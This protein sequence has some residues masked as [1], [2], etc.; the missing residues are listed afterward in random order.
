MN[1]AITLDDTI[2]KTSEMIEKYKKEYIK[3]NNISVDIFINNRIYQEYFYKEYIELIYNSVLLKSY[4]KKALRYLNENNNIYIITNRN[5]LYS[6]KVKS[7]TLNYLLRNGIDV[8]GI[9]FDCKDKFKFCKKNKIDIIIDNNIDNYKKFK[10]AKIKYI[11]YDDKEKYKN[12]DSIICSWKYDL[13][14]ETLHFIM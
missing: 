11:L 8:S 13:V 5:N 1:I 14:Y 12:M 2:C 7:L 6:Y 3:N 4:F 10:R 9:V